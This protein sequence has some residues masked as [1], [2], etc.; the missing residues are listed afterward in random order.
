MQMYDVSTRDGLAAFVSIHEAAF[1]TLH[2]S[3]PHATTAA[4]TADLVARLGR[5]RA[6]LD[7]PPLPSSPAKPLDA[8]AVDYIV[9]GSRLGTRVL[10][11][12]WAAS[13]DIAVLRADAYFTAPEKPDA[14][15][16][17]CREA[18]AYPADGDVAD[19][20]LRSAIEGFAIFADAIV[21]F[22]ARIF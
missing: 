2:N 20:I 10:R 7:V 12:R 1:A 21:A 18:A 6:A 9:L 19:D 15:R 13:D 8:N 16:D 22:E 4:Q 17:F 14:W 11:K 3:A 5:D